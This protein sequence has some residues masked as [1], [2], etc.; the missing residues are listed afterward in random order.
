M[1]TS[2]LD[3]LTIP[4]SAILAAVLALTMLSSS[5]VFS[6]PAPVD[7]LMAGFMATLVILGGGR[8]GLAT[9]SNLTLWLPV[10]A[11]SFVATTFSPDFNKAVIHQVVTLF[12][13][14]SAVAIAAYVATD[15][16]PRARL[17]LNWYVAGTAI[18]CLLAYIGYFKLIPGAY[19]LFTN[20]G[21]ARGAFKDPNVFGAALGPALT[22][23]CWQLLRQPVRY[24]LI[25][26]VLCLFMAP[27][28]LIS[29]SRGAW[30]SVAVSLAVLIFFALTRTRRTTDHFRMAA[31]AIIGFL[32]I[33]ITLTAVLQI[34]QVSDLMRERASLTNSYDEGPEGRF[35]GQQ[36]GV[37]LII[38]NPLGI[39]THTFR[40]V[41][42]HEEVH[43][44]YLTMFHNAGWIGGFLFIATILLTFAQ[45]IAGA[46]RISSFQG[47]I[48]VATASMAGLIVEGLVIDSDH[49]RH[50]FIVMGLI[51]GLSDAKH[52][53]TKAS[54]RWYDALGS[55]ARR[56]RTGNIR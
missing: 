3:N 28:L 7:V 39:G 44:V 37:R 30:I 41:H 42:H 14:L 36:K 20:Y 5:I 12:L 24:S 18:A 15:P 11:L 32:S 8:L 6:E 31:F 50:L 34:P 56:L 22:Y 25:P 29:F 40:E 27:A 51:W 47:P 21:R 45:G 10:L 23:L 52:H 9:L 13:V 38:E 2:A 54:H 17:V 4:R 19:D 48:V 46:L 26:A 55:N 33:A 43:N 35:G 1:P 49:W 53:P 16:E